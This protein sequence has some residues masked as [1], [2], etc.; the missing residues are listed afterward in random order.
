VITFKAHEFR[1]M[2]AFD[3]SARANAVDRLLRRPPGISAKIGLPL[4]YF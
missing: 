1:V 4:A 2:V 3:P